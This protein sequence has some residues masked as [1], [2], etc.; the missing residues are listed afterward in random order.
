MLEGLILDLLA[1]DPWHAAAL[2]VDRLLM[3]HVFVVR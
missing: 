2:I 1:A 3:D